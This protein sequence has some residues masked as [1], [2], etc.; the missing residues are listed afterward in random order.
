DVGGGGGGGDAGGGSASGLWQSVS[1]G[2]GGRGARDSGRGVCRRR[3]GLEPS[4]GPAGATCECVADRGAAAAADG[5][6]AVAAEWRRGCQRPRFDA[7][8]GCGSAL[9]VYA[10]LSEISRGAI[11]AAAVALAVL[12]RLPHGL[13]PFFG[14]R[15]CAVSG[16]P[17][18]AARVCLFP[19]NPAGLRAGVPGYHR[20]IDARGATARGS[21]A[22]DFHAR[23]AALPSYS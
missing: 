1:D 9:A 6:I 5:R 15:R 3:A 18:S 22:I 19:A 13:A 20:R 2:T 10:L 11:I 12:C 8:R 21:V 17:G 14:D 7:L 23:Y 16:R 4:G